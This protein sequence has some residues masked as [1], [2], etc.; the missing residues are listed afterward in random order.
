MMVRGGTIKIVANVIFTR[1][2]D[3][4]RGMSIA[5]DQSGFDG[6]VLNKA[7]AEASTDEGDV[8]FDALAGNAQCL[9]DRLRGGAGNL[10][11]RPEFAFAIADM[12]GAIWRFHGGVRQERDFVNRFELF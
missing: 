8:D 5:G 3:L 6:V 1:P 7:A 10:C 9:S 12:G 11:G 4:D 2:D